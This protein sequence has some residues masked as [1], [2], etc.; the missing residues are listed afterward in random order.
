MTGPLPLAVVCGATD[1]VTSAC[2]SILEES[3]AV[4]Q[5]AFAVDGRP[6]LGASPDEVLE[7]LA[8]LEEK[9]GPLRSL[10]VVLPQG[11]S[12]IA[13]EEL[14][15]SEWRALIDAVLTRTFVVV[16]A[17][18]RL[19][20]GHGTGAIAVVSTL[21]GLGGVTG[22]AHVCAAAAG[23]HGF[24]EAAAIEWGRHG[25][26]INLVAAPPLVRNKA[27]REMLLDRTPS[28]REVRAVDI[29]GAVGFALAPSASQLHGAVLT[30]D[31]G[32]SS[33]LITRWNGADLASS[34][35][36]ERGLYA[37]R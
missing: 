32:L 10:A 12:E 2:V 36:L 5:Q 19:M 23:V 31:G 17:A 21:D 25:V 22:R 34:V 37:T 29:A 9:Y 27:E 3:A 26:R 28:A 7:A 30:V 6:G 24:V 20:I 18:G 4:V 33:G 35:L 13:A 1:V 11:A 15:A 16:Q 14:D 8:A